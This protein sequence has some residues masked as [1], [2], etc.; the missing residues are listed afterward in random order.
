[1]LHA[2]LRK[3]V[4]S[5]KKFLVRFLNNQIQTGYFKTLKKE[6][7]LNGLLYKDFTKSKVLF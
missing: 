5:T 7:L 1:M 4:E 6:Q 2:A 3:T